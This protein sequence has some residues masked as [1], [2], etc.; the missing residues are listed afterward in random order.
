[1]AASYNPNR[2]PYQPQGQADH[3]P[4]YH[5]G[6]GYLPQDQGT[7][8]EHPSPPVEDYPL[9]G[10]PPRAQA[11]PPPSYPALAQGPPPAYNSKADQIAYNFKPQS[12]STAV[13]VA[14]HPT[15]VTATVVS[16]PSEDYSRKAVC[17]LVFSICTLITCGV[18]LVGLPFS[19][20]ALILSIVA[21]RT[22][23]ASQNGHAQ[24]SI[25]LNIVVVVFNA[26]LLITAC[27][28]I[29]I[30]VTADTRAASGYRSYYRSSY[31][32]YRPTYYYGLG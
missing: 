3:S 24:L 5:A 29:P 26:T 25:A 21:L 23:G 19:I 1:M 4:E 22:K 14:A 30:V 15:T 17:S 2:Q 10:H 12:G 6:N 9:H 20:P 28:V 8:V 32:R 27:I 7:S 18:S 31:Y 13:V 16:Q 11:E